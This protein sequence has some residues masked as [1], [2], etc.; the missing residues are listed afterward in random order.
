MLCF[1]S[2]I[3]KAQTNHYITTYSPGA[4][5]FNYAGYKFNK[6]YHQNPLALNYTIK[7]GTKGIVVD[8]IYFSISYGRNYENKFPYL[9]MRRGGFINI[10]YLKN[11]KESNKLQFNL[12][13]GISSKITSDMITIN[14]Y[15][16]GTWGESNSDIE[17]SNEWGGLGINLGLNLKY[18]LSHRFY[19]NGG[20]KTTNF[21][22]KTKYQTNTIFT[23]CGIGLKLGKIK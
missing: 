7:K 11:I 16:N 5:F 19:L 2:N 23:E 18:F 21:I 14:Q 22:I 9:Q 10:S 12:L 8:L 3:I 13:G 15:S 6:P 4:Y 17:A 1:L 20:V